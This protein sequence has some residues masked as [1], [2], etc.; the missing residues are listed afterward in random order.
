LASAADLDDL[1]QV[2]GG[3]VHGSVAKV[4]LTLGVVD[5][6]SPVVVLSVVT[7]VGRSDREA[8][9]EAQAV[10]RSAEPAPSRLSADGLLLTVLD[11][12]VHVRI[13]DTSGISTAAY[14]GKTANPFD[15]EPNLK[16]DLRGR[17]S[18]GSEGL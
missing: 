13:V 10:S 15:G 3:E 7:S 9:C 14:H 12:S 18:G 8:V 11:W 2:D 1:L 17:F 16:S 6:K 4:D 5:G